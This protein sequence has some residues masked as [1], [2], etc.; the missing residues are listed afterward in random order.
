MKIE[1]E[2]LQ[3]MWPMRHFLITCGTLNGVSNII[4]VSF[5]MPVSKEPPLIA[6]AVGKFT[7][8]NV[9]IEEQQEFVV[10]VP[11]KELETKIYYCGYVSGFKKDKFKEVGLTKEPAQKVKAPIIKECVAHMECRVTQKIETGDKNLFIGEVVEAYADEDI[12]KGISKV[13]FAGGD[14]PRKV[15]STRFNREN[16]D[17][18]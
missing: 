11:T 3:F 7:H 12:V 15:Y 16:R 14:F 9:L 13:E 2:Y 4:A 8:S 6:C 1:V 18:K 10:N 17:E 5:C